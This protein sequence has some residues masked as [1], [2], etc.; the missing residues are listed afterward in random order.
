MKELAMTPSTEPYRFLMFA[1]AIVVIAV[2]LLTGRV[3]LADEAG[4]Y[5]PAAP[6]GSAFVRV[7]NGSSQSLLGSKIGP[8]DFN[9]VPAFEAS[10][11][12]FLPPGT[13][14]VNAGGSQA[15]ATL[16]ADRYYTAALVNGKLQLLDNARYGNRMKALVMVYNLVGD[17]PLALKT[18]DGKTTVVEPVAPGATGQREVNAIKAQFAVYKG[19]QRLAQAR[20]VTLE[21][22]RAFSLFV[23]GTAAQPTPVW[24]I[25]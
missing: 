19:E 9:E 13:Y 16:K 21:R 7:F 5:G 17:A 8:E 4:L 12:T 15:Q 14:T 1:L 2:L 11:F 6:P 3:A 25:N 10:E 24:V 18:G 20:P 22:G 23:V